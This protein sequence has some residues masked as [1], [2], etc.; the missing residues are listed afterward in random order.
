MWTLSAEVSMKV[1]GYHTSWRYAE[2]HP[3]QL[4][5]YNYQRL[6]DTMSY[7]REIYWPVNVLSGIAWPDQLPRNAVEFI[8]I[9]CLM[10]LGQLMFSTLVGALS[11]LMENFNRIRRDFDHKVDKI[12]LLVKYKSVSKEI[13]G[14]ISRYYEYIWARYGGVDEAEV[15]RDLPKSLRAAVANHVLGPLL[16]R[17]PFFDSCSEP[18]EQMIVSLFETRIFLQDDAL[19]LCGEVGQDMFIIEHGEVEITSADR[20]ITYARLKGGDYVGESCFLDITKRTASAFAV[21][22]VDTYFLTRDNFLKVNSA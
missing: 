18:M 14:K 22:Y 3:G 8:A 12:R 17:V 19:M 9:T 5:F 2:T 4:Y 6:A 13:E 21:D 20:S 1:F 16:K 7:W 11:S 15:M 10:M